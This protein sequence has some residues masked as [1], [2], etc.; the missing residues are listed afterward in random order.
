MAGVTGSANSM[1]G[2]IGDT[3]AAVQLATRML[4]AGW[5]FLKRYPLSASLIIA[6]VA[7]AAYSRRPPRHSTRR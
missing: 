1:L 6:G 3:A 7:W 4:P 2:H 5:R